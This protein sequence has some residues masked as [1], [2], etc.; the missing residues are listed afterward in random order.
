MASSKTGENLK[1]NSIASYCICVKGYLDES[2]S[3]RFNGMAIDNMTTGNISP[4]TAL[5]GT[6]AFHS[7][8]DAAHTFSLRQPSV[9]HRPVTQGTHT[10]L[11]DELK[12]KKELFQR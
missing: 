5:V 1:Y 6:P 2:W 11:I 7:C 3:E 12:R 4:L 8:P 10:L 9:N